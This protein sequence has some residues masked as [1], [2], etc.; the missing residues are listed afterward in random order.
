M[1]SYPQRIIDIVF[2]HGCAKREEI[3]NEISRELG[4]PKERVEA[5]VDTA[6]ERLVRRGLIV[7]KSK[8]YYCSPVY[9]DRMHLAQ[10]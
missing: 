6:L 10:T 5:A 3:L 4:V 8:G 1:V 7:R 9:G 2:K